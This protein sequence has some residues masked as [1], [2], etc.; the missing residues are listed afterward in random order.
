MEEAVNA[1]TDVNEVWNVDAPVTPRPPPCTNKVDANVAIPVTPRVDEAVNAPT[2]VNEVWKVEAPVIPMPPE[3]TNKAALCEATPA[4]LDV[5]PNMAVPETP[6]PV[7]ILTSP[8]TPSPPTIVNAPEVDEVEFVLDVS[9]RVPIFT[10]EP[11]VATPLTVRPP[12]TP[13]PPAVI[14]TFEASVAT[15]VTPRVDDA[16]N[17][18]TDVNDVWNI[19]APVTPIQTQL[20]QLLAH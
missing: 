16:V 1:P 18:P 10:V 17:A 5:E 11:K 7:P 19:D 6:M 15:P 4:K 20:H 2:E 3:V 13:K 8:D 12:V 9:A 14:F